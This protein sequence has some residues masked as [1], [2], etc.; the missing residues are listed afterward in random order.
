MQKDV[1]AVDIDLSCYNEL[2]FACACAFWVCVHSSYFSLRSLMVLS[3]PLPWRARGEGIA[4]SLQFLFVSFFL[5]QCAK[6]RLV[7][8][9]HDART[10]RNCKSFLANAATFRA[11]NQEPSPELDQLL[12]VRFWGKVWYTVADIFHKHQVISAISNHLFHT[13]HSTFTSLIPLTQNH[14]N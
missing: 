2:D 12:L 3:C 1:P 8:C 9:R 6:S 10:M 7:L 11:A 14:M 13:F 5:N 4:I